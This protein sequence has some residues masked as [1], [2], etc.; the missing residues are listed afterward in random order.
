MS[1]VLWIISART[2]EKR[3]KLLDVAS[4]H[5][6]HFRTCRCRSRF[7]HD[8]NSQFSLA[9]GVSAEQKN[10]PNSTRNCLPRLLTYYSTKPNTEL[11]QNMLRMARH[12][13]QEYCRQWKGH[14]QCNPQKVDST[15]S[16]C[17]CPSIM[18]AAGGIQKIKRRMNRKFRREYLRSCRYDS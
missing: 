3:K 4:V 5:C 14:T 6:S 15:T 2:V 7:L 17:A 1:Y 11:K 8:R 9:G 13:K 10:I 16:E 12:A 18:A